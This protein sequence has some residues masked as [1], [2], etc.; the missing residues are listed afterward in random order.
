[1]GLTSSTSTK[2]YAYDSPTSRYMQTIRVLQSYAKMHLCAD[3][4]RATYYDGLNIGVF[5]MSDS[6]ARAP[7]DNKQDTIGGVAGERTKKTKI[8]LCT[9][10][11]LFLLLCFS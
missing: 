3:G 1:M 7:H 5:E 4:S 6:V 8:K 2:M 11:R 10:L 9:F